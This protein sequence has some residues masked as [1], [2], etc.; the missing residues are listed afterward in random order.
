MAHMLS[1]LG[2]GLLLGVSSAPW[3]PPLRDPT[4]PLFV[5]GAA[6]LP[7]PC[8]EAARWSKARRPLATRSAA[9]RKL[10]PPCTELR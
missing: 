9:R 5:S 2:L 1:A 6:A 3:P 10:P 7:A 8:L 4:A